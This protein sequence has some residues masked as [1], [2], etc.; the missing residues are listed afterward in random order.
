[1]YPNQ[2]QSLPS[3][4]LKYFSILRLIYFQ[5]DKTH[6]SFCNPQLSKFQSERTTNSPQ[7][8]RQELAERVKEVTQLRNELDRVKK[9]KNITSGLVTQM[10]RDM[11]NKVG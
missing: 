9:D 4:Y 7:L 3:S 5:L 10:Q 1:M 11:S 6:N 8:L 2:H